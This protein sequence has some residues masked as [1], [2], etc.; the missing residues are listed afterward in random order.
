MSKMLLRNE[1]TRII[2]MNIQ[3]FWANITKVQ[4]GEIDRDAWLPRAN[5][6]F[7]AMNITI[8]RNHSTL[9]KLGLIIWIAWQTLTSCIQ[10]NRLCWLGIL[11]LLSVR[12]DY[13]ISTVSTT[14]CFNFLSDVWFDIKVF[15]INIGSSH[16]IY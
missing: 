13:S 11:A 4:K 6:C 2:A 8:Q 14:R 16:I 15:I 5:F 3:L 12:N 9:S 1:L 10:A 7:I